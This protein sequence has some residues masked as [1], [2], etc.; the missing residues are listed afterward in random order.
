VTAEATVH[1]SCVAVAGKGLLIRG[2]SGSGK[3]GLALQLMALGARLVA[4]DRTSLFRKG[5][6][7]FASCPPALSGMIEA[8]GIGILRA[9]P[10][11]DVKLWLVADLGMEE[12]ERLPPARQCDLL[13]VAVD[14][15]L[16]AR[17][18]HLP[19]ALMRYLTDGRHA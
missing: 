3:S 18:D 17:G 1:A 10:V 14:L 5:E 11:P 13:G 12:T 19:A 15:V 7:V 9:E 8:R 2:P 16:K 6:A 4:D